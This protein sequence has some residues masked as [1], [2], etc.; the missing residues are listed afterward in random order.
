MSLVVAEI[1]LAGCIKESNFQMVG[2]ARLIV[3]PLRTHSGVVA[4]Q[5][6]EVRWI[7]AKAGQRNRG[8]VC[9][10]AGRPLS[11][12]TACS[13]RCLRCWDLLHLMDPDSFGLEPNCL[14]PTRKPTGRPRDFLAW[15]CF[16]SS[17]SPPHAS[18]LSWG[19]FASALI[20][21]VDGFRESDERRPTTR[22]VRIDPRL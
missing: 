7:L 22:P 21:L 2:T 19:S 10:T 18:S 14:C 16:P 8:P 3:S 5:L 15:S 12:V 4:F 11:L 6:G 17:L 1:K 20:S 13:G 9:F